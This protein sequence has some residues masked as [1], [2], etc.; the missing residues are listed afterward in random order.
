MPSLGGQRRALFFLHACPVGGVL[1]FTH[2]AADE[3]TKCHLLP[4]AG[5]YIFNGQ[6]DKGV[7]VLEHARQLLFRG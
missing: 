2:R 7:E 4:P 3:K 5:L 6:I 1:L